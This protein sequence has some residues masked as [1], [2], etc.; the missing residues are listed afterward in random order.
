LSGEYYDDYDEEVFFEDKVECS[1]EMN[2]I[3]SNGNHQHQN[4]LPRMRET[5]LNGE[6]ISHGFGRDGDTV[7]SVGGQQQ[8]NHHERLHHV[9]QGLEKDEFNKIIPEAKKAPQVG[10]YFFS[11]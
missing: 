4:S 9:P 1:R 2:M 3:S 8:L 10:Q 6:P 11:Q 5:I 7:R